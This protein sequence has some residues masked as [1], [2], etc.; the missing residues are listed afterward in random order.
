MTP[1][2]IPRRACATALL[3]LTLLSSAAVAQQVVVVGV[4]PIEGTWRL[5]AHRAGREV[6]RPPRADGFFSVRDGIVLFQLRRMVGDTVFG[7]YGS[8]EYSGAGER[9]SYAYD[10]RVSVTRRPTG[11]EVRDVIPFKGPR[12][13]QAPSGGGGSRYEADGGRYV[14]EVLGDTLIYSEDGSWLRRWIRVRPAASTP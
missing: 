6:L 7:F 10:R 1:G 14:F 11:V 2:C 12:L 3:E 13:F 4:S 8:G 9:F 5:V